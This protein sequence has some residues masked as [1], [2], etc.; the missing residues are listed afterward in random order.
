MN[1]ALDFLA[2]TEWE[3]KEVA[4][5]QYS[6]KV[7]P[8]CGDE[9]WKFYMSYDGLWDCKICAESGN[10]YQLKGKLGGIDEISSIDSLFRDKRELD[11]KILDEYV[12]SLKNDKNA[13]EYL[14]KIRGF[15]PETIEKFKLGVDGNWI[16][17][18]HFQNE[19]LWNLKMRNYKE[20]DFRRVSGQPSVL[21]NIDNIDLKKKALVIVE[22]ETDCIA[23]SQMGIKNVVGLTTG[24]GT[25]LPEWIP[26]TLK[27]KEIYICLNSDTAGQKGAYSMAE[28][29]GLE[30]CRNVILPVKDVNDY[31]QEHTGDDFYKLVK[32]AKRFNIKNI[33]DVAE[34]IR[35]LDEW[36]DSGEALNGLELPFPKIN[37]YLSG[38][39]EE[40]MIIISGDTGVGK[41]TICFNIVD[42]FLKNGKRCLVFLLEGKIKYH[43][44]RM[45]SAETHVKT[46]DIQKDKTIVPDWEEVKKRFSDY[47]LYFYSGTQSD[48]DP[49]KLAELLM[50]AVKLYDIDFVMIDNLQKFVKG[51][52]DLVVQE[53]SRTVS[54]IKDLAVDL[55]IPIMLITHIRKPVKGANRVTMHDA[56]SS[57]TIYQDADIYLT[58]WNNKTDNQEGDD[59]VLSIEKNRMGEG[60]IDIRMT[61]EKEIGEYHE[62]AGDAEKVVKRKKIDKN[63]TWEEKGFD[64]NEKEKDDGFK[65]I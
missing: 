63:V 50:A 33:K 37:K 1:I 60:G 52:F 55:K 26:F 19:K 18:P 39:K 53:T 13:Y 62:R 25:F 20:K 17:I 58:L 9:R 64:D 40:D 29:L 48:M 36:L 65:K 11:I 43:L 41:T 51:D 38:F 15:T 44:L 30:K 45:M 28:K 8:L 31:M 16:V 23:A 24:A 21:F 35:D 22:S 4:N 34:Y 42:K 46:A 47:P 61:Y 6:V 54:S 32:N 12:N 49:K 2:K 56:K 10:L 5:K 14:T 27:F 57:S 3:Y 7:C 59:M